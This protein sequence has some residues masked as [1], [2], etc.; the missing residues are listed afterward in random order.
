MGERFD[1]AALERCIGGSRDYVAARLGVATKTVD[2]FRREGLSED[3]ADRY[4]VRAGHHPGEVWPE[5]WWND[6][7]TALV[8]VRMWAMQMTTCHECGLRFARPRHRC[9]W[10][11]EKNERQEEIPA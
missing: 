2:R 6:D 11:N 1:F 10:C 8:F 4:A 5:Q 7:E 3:T 9:P